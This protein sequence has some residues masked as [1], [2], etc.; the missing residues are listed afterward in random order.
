MTQ[1]MYNAT[2]QRQL[3]SDYARAIARAADKESAR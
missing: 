3:D 2:R 1:H